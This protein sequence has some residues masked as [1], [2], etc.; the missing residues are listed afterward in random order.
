MPAGPHDPHPHAPIDAHEP[1]PDVEAF[2]G[3]PGRRGVLTG[4]AALAAA[5]L[6]A[7][8]YAD[9]DDDLDDDR[10][11]KKSRRVRVTVLGT[12]DL[13]R[14]RLQLGLLQGR[15]VRRH[16]AQRHRP[17][18]GLHAGQ[19]D[20]RAERRKREPVAAA[21]RRRHHPGH[22]AGL[23]LRQDRADH[24]RR[25]A[26]DGRGDERHRLR[27]RRARQPRVQLRHRHAAHV[28][29]QLDFPLLGANAVDPATKR[30]VFPPYIIKRVRVAGAASRSR[31]ASSA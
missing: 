26:P 9:S 6:A 17:G 13:P 24:R 27:R 1:H 7:P 3:L 11:G 30:P 31:S 4:A 21:R 19:G 14:Q 23:L 28:R 12:T 16:R 10:R 5:G 20:A 22:A 29:A 25:R 18:Q 15:R 8:A 2:G